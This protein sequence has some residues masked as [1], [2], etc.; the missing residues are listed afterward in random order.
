MSGN[1]LLTTPF[2][3]L[4]YPV[5][6]ANFAI[7]CIYPDFLCKKA[8]PPVEQNRLKLPESKLLRLIYLAVIAFIEFSAVGEVAEELTH[9]DNTA[10][11]EPD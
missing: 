5:I 8:A 3:N 10:D 4:Q 2:V 1:I 9:I 11:K 7:R 6:T